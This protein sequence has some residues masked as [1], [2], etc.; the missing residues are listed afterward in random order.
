MTPLVSVVIPAYNCARY[1]AEAVQSVLDQDYPATEV[2]VVND[3]STDGTLAVL[4][5]FGAAIRGVDQ[6]KQRPAGGAQQRARGR[7]RRLCC[8]PRLR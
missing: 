2:V 7:A 3:G 4:R 1:V 8:V 6:K 5:E